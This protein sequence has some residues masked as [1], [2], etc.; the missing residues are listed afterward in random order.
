MFTISRGNP[1]NPFREGEYG[2]ARKNPQGTPIPMPTN[3]GP[4]LPDMFPYGV[5]GRPAALENPKAK[6]NSIL[7]FFRKKFGMEPLPSVTDYVR[8]YYKPGM[9][10]DYLFDIAN[11]D[12]WDSGMNAGNARDFAKQVRYEAEQSSKVRNTPPS[13][14]R[15]SVCPKCG[16]SNLIYQEGSM[17]CGSC[18]AY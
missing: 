13:Q 15:P 12:A 14:S 16:S 3:A 2:A 18:G 5:G 7:K 9:D 10:M 17:S 6:K 11:Q 8:E 1:K 4:Y